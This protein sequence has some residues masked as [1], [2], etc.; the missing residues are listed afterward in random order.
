MQFEFFGR[1]KAF[2]LAFLFLA[3][4]A[5]SPRPIFAREGVN[6]WYIKD[7]KSELTVNPDSS[8][9]V[10]ERI[11]ADC[12]TCVGKHG[13]FRILPTV[14]NTTEGKIKTPVELLGITDFSG[15]PYK[16]QTINDHSQGTVT[17]KIG[18]PNITV[19]GEN[20]Y[21]ISYRVKNAIRQ[22]EK[23]DEL[24]WNLTGNFWDIDIDNF[25]ANITLPAG[26]NSQNTKVEYY[27]GY[28]GEKNHDLAAYEWTGER[29]LRFSSLKTIYTRE[30]IT[31]SAA[32]PKGLVAP[33]VP[34]MADYFRW[35]F[36][37]FLLPIVVFIFSFRLWKKYGDD[38][39]LKKAI[40]PEYE[41]PDNLGSLEV[42][43][44]RANGTVKNNFITAAIIKMACDK[45]LV[46]REIEEKKFLFTRKD[47]EI[48]KTA[49]ETQIAGLL[50]PERKI[51]DTL[52][53]KGSPVRISELKK[54]F[55]AILDY[56]K[57]AVQDELVNGGYMEKTGFTMGVKMLLAVPI[58][59]IVL[60]FITKFYSPSGLWR[61]KGLKLYMESAE[62]D[63]QR[64][65]ETEGIF[66]KLLP[67]AIVFGMTK[68]WAEKVRQIY[69]DEYM[70]AH[71][72]AW[73]VASASGGGFDVN[74][75]ASEIDHL[76][77]AISQSASP[78]SGAGGGGGSGGGGGG[79]G[80][81]GW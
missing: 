5:V 81:G 65:Y 31:A 76:S 11:T 2:L 68:Q 15:Q 34:T 22:Q 38:P 8:L 59:L 29:T 25:T 21:Q 32:F 14:L 9:T 24:Y 72:P 35:D 20:Y 61:I 50:P 75:F 74:N 53:E 73:Y 7:F 70:R 63:R 48:E 41:P 13:I 16:Y 18:D 17:W 28:F 26:A 47:F 36:L 44:L 60:F 46:I 78:S 79:G 58:F 45:L 42:G 12:G 19:R 80:G 71:A 57:R 51:F 52:F 4:L 69:G 33:Y 62:K 43:A 37:W 27:T 30:G 56:I 77:S 40:M 3:L 6:Y 66:D 49:T 1:K 23:F 39:N 55:L 64:F 10:V 67:Y 54:D